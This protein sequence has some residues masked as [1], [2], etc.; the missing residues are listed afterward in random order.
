MIKRSSKMKNMNVKYC[1][2]IIPFMMCMYYMK[3]VGKRPAFV[4]YQNYTF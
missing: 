3:V 2:L 1:K 4:L